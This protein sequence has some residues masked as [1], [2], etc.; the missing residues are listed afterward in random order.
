MAL[1]AETINVISHLLINDIN[2]EPNMF[3]ITPFFAT[4][5]PVLSDI[6]LKYGILTEVV[7]YLVGIS[8]VS[9]GL[10]NLILKKKN[11]KISLKNS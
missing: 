9:Y 3:Y 4:K 7:I 1:V 6:A 10:Y 2:R 8:L 11:N 5:Q